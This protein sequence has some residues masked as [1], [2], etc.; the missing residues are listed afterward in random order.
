MPGSA[1]LEG[2][3]HARHA[4][5][6]LGRR[7]AARFVVHVFAV[8]AGAFQ[9]FLHRRVLS[10]LAVGQAGSMTQQ[11]LHGHRPL[12]RNDVVGRRVGRLDGNAD[13]HFVETGEEFAD[14]VGEL[15]A[16]VLD[17]H[18]RRNRGERLGHRVDAEDAVFAHR[19][20]RALHAY[21][22]L[23]D[24]L[25]LPRH[26]HHRAAEAAVGDLLLQRRADL[27][28]PLRRHAHRLRL[29]HRKRR[30]RRSERRE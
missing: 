7:H 13:A 15:D 14:R 25:A 19:H 27:C 28:E 12:R 4:L 16:A 3:R 29:G 1:R 10:D 5:D 11:V 22:V 6:L 24:E 21:R 26:H 8:D 17:E 20:R 2:E 9:A 30:L 23:V 18:H